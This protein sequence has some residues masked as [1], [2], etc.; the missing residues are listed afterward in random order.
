MKISI[1]PTTPTPRR[2][3]VA[4]IGLA[5][6][7]GALGAG[8]ADGLVTGGP[9]PV[10]TAL[11]AAGVALWLAPALGLALALLVALDRLGALGAWR[12]QPAQTG[13]AWLAASAVFTAAVLV[14]D[15]VGTFAG[16]T[17][18]AAPLI[19]PLTL[20]GAAAAALATALI[21]RPLARLAVAAWGGCPGGW[22]WGPPA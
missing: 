13:G 5:A 1:L 7:L 6:A 18:Q 4:R 11:T 19:A 14:G 8:L 2:R 16:H 3:L 9:A 17:V 22:R 10:A 12:H 21:A 20:A 15:R